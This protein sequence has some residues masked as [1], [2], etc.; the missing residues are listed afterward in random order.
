M[1]VFCLSC[2][3]I[4]LFSSFATFS[5]LAK[6]LVFLQHWCIGSM[7]VYQADKIL[8]Q[9]L[10]C[11][12]H[13]PN[14]DKWKAWLQLSGLVH[15]FVVSGSH[16]IVLEWLLQFLRIPKVI[17][18]F[19]LWIY[20]AI[21]GFSPPGTRACLHLSIGFLF[22]V[23]EEQKV[24]AVA[25]ACLALQPSWATSYSFWLSWLA[26]VILI[27]TP[28]FKIDL[29]R[30][31]IFYGAWLLLGFTIS[32]WAIPMNLILGPF[33]SWILFPLAFLSYIPGV[34]LLFH[35]SV[36]IL[37]IILEWFSAEAKVAPLPV[38]LTQLAGLVLLT[39]F[40]LQIRR[41]LWQGKKIK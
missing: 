11:A 28:R 7:P 36:L 1:W 8:W 14:N 37:K 10:V 33:I 31:F 15:L 41:L 25:L 39:H 30:N 35:Y 20:N 21:T 29:L 3:F 17:R 23:P 13:F 38:L 32:I 24:F 27:V 4:M 6:N 34:E 5:Y 12:Q 18:F 19:I 2:L 9:A 26:S 16:F 40:V 22:K